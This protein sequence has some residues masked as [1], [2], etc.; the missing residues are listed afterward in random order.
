MGNGLM[1]DLATFKRELR[2]AILRQ[3]MTKVRI[4]SEFPDEHLAPV[5]HPGHPLRRLT[6][7]EYMA[8][9]AEADEATKAVE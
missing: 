3:R 1:P 7:E 4:S 5:Q 9:Q 8:L 6:K 2:A